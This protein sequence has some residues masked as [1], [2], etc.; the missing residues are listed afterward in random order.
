MQVQFGPRRMRRGPENLRH[1]RAISEIGRYPANLISFSPYG[2]RGLSIVSTT[3]VC[4]CLRS[5]IATTGSKSS[6][7]VGTNETE[8]VRSSWTISRSAKRRYIR[9]PLSF[10]RTRCQNM[11]GASVFF[12]VIH[13]SIEFLQLGSCR[14]STVRAEKVKPGSLRE[15][16][17]IRYDDLKHTSDIFV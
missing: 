5:D 4:P 11:S 16:G 13:W 7:L 17:N 9:L 3:T 2:P 12:R 14:N 6:L 1:C 8:C 10:A 15:P